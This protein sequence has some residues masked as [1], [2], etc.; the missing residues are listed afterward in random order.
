VPARDPAR[1]PERLRD[2]PRGQADFNSGVA[3]ALVA[4]GVP[5]VVANQYKV[6]DSS[7]TSKTPPVLIFSTKGPGLQSQGPPADRTVAN[8][9]VSCLYGVLSGRD[10][11]GAPPRDCPNDTSPMRR[12]DVLTGPQRLCAPCAGFLGKIDPAAGA[13]LQAI[14]RVFD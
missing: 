6:L 3:P 7:A 9:L 14:L 11:L 8:A 10:S 2:A 12:L 4:A 5:I 1:L 13:A